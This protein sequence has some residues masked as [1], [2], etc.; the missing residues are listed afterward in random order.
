MEGNSVNMEN[1]FSRL[2]LDIIGKAVFN[3]DFDSLTH[4]DPVIEVS[5]WSVSLLFVNHLL[6]QQTCYVQGSCLSSAHLSKT[7]SV[8]D[9]LQAVYTV[10]REA[11]HRSTAPIAYW[12]IPGAKQLIPRQRACVEALQVGACGVGAL[13]CFCSLLQFEIC[14]HNCSDSTCTNC[15]LSHAILDLSRFLRRLLD[16]SHPF[17]DREHYAGRADRK[18]QENGKLVCSFAPMQ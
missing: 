16:L 18:V 15:C 6:I 14:R 17:T 13:T 11:E 4:D 3:Y 7:Q 1:Y 12:D 10:L 9:T 2:T 5:G 8:P